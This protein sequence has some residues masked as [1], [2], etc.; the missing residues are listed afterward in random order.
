MDIFKFKHSL[1][2]P[3]YDILFNRIKLED[4]MLEVS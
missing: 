1:A 2:G 3:P 4:Q